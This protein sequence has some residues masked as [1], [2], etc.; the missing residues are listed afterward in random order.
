MLFVI[1]TCYDYYLIVIKS[2][3]N[4]NILIKDTTYMT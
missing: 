1:L 3:K 4:D 2:D